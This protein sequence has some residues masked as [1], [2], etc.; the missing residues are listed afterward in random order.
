[1]LCSAAAS[2]GADR[3][4][5]CTDR[6]PPAAACTLKPPVDAKTSRTSRPA[7][8][9][10]TRMR[11]ARWSRKWPVFCPLRTSASNS[12][13]ASTNRTGPSGRSPAITSPSTSPK[14][15]RVCRLRARRSTTPVHPVRSS[16]ALTTETRWGNQT[17]EYSLITRTPAKRSTTRPDTPSF[18]PLSTRY[19]SRSASGA[20]VNGARTASAALIVDRHQSASIGVGL[21]TWRTRNW[22]GESG[23]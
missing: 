12:R 6:A 23:S 2:V 9:A 8:I 21:P 5:A 20:V 15:S 7:D 10:P 22:I 4:T 11:F 3:S 16:S 13:P 1:M 19:A 18:S 14:V 17:A